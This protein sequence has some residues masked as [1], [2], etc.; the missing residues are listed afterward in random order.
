MKKIRTQAAFGECIVYD[1]HSY[2]YKR[3]ERQDLPVL[4]LGTTSVNSDRWRPVIDG[5]LSTLQA[6]QVDGIEV[7]AAENDIFF[8]KG[9][10]AAFCHGN[11]DGT[12]VLATEAKKVF[13]DELT[14]EA[15]SVVLPSLQKAYNAS[16]AKHTKAYLKEFHG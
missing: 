14:G 10:L 8:G 2:N 11:Y 3:H 1:N 15:D 5:W 7:T 16:I 4:N 9:Y 12:L 13:M 6:M